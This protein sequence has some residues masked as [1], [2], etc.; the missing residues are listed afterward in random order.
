MKG[1]VKSLPRCLKSQLQLRLQ[2]SSD[3]EED[4][5]RE[6]KQI[7]D[8]ALEVRKSSSQKMFHGNALLV[9]LVCK[10]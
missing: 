5:V 1:I 9:S 2:V 4:S 7:S 10:Y 8:Q 6:V 3:F